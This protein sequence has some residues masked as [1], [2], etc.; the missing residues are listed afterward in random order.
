MKR[1]LIIG[2]SGQDGAYLSKLLLTKKYQ[3]WG[4]SRDVHG[5][6][7]TKLSKQEQVA[8]LEKEMP[9]WKIKL[10]GDVNRNLSDTELLNR[11]YY[12]GRFASPR[13]V[14]VNDSKYMIF[15]WE[16]TLI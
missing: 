14:D 10:H 6:D 12:R 3:V 11:E 15:N 1:A 7:F 5:A 9:N 16:E 8:Q 4:T 13:L 2:V